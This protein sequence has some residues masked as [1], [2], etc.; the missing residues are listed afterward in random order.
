MSKV[1][2]NLEIKS[3]EWQENLLN[4]IKSLLNNVLNY[5]VVNLN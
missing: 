4:R 3:S 1:L 2:W 5:F